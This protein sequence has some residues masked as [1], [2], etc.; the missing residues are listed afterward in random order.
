MYAVLAD[1]DTIPLSPEE[2]DYEL[3]QYGERLITLIK[4]KLVERKGKDENY[5]RMSNYG[6]PDRKLWY[7]L[8]TPELA[9]DLPPEAFLKFLYG[10]N[11]EELL[12]LLA[13]LAGHT[14]EGCQD[15]QIVAGVKGSRDAVIDGE[16]VD[17]KSAS[18]FSFKKFKNHELGQDDPFHYLDQLNL[19]LTAAQDDPIVTR[20]DRAHFLVMDKQLGHL[21]LDTYPIRERDYSTEV[22]EKM[23]MLGQKEPPRRCHTAVPDGKAGN[24]KLGTECSYCAF[25]NTCYPNL[26]TFLYANGPRFLTQ[27]VRVP[28]V[29]EAARQDPLTEVKK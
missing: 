1:P 23:E 21:C 8:N 22:K 14:V 16:L 25:K 7:T 9:E 4:T 17:V 2:V 11:I 6:T 3:K 12:L 27:V 19:Y 5:L 18:T 20:K 26:R 29:P 28:D 24:M 15:V 13:R 10:D